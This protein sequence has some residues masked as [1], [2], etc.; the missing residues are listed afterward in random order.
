[1]DE[2]KIHELVE[3]EPVV[4]DQ[5]S[6]PTSSIDRAQR[7]LAEHGVAVLTNALPPGENSAVRKRLLSAAEHSE[8]RGIPTRG[9]GLDPDENNRRVLLLFNLDPIF[10]D[11]IVRPVAIQFVAAALEG[12]F[13]ISN[14]SANILGPGAGSMNLHAD[15]MEVNEPWPAKPIGINVGWLLDDFT[16]EVGA[17]RYVPGSHRMNKNPEPGKP[18]E[19]VAVEAPA[20]SI[21]VM[22]SRLWHQGGVNRTL[23]RHRA[24]AFG[25]YVRPWIRTQV[26][27]TSALDATVAATLDESLLELLGYNRGLTKIKTD[28]FS[29]ASSVGKTS[30]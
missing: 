7:D 30:M 26:N 5:Y 4:T 21:L 11:L 20:G 29:L 10:L 19:T 23:D 25:Y 24:A 22:D 28:S 16:D 27:W 15:Q 14:F 6:G 8:N 18:Y 12:R 17:T 1:M 2:T 9:Y 13:S 3:E